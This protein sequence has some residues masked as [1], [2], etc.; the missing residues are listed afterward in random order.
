[1]VREKV[2]RKLRRPRAGRPAPLLDQRSRDLIGAYL[3]SMYRE[4]L[5]EPL[6]DRFVEVLKCLNQ[7]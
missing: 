1:M 3:Q 5:T 2:R 6:P 7:H 4:L